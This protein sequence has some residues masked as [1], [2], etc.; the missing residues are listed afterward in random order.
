MSKIALVITFFF[1]ITS[2][3]KEETWSGPEIPSHFPEV[4][5]KN[6]QNRKFT[7]AGFLLGKRL[8]F[9]PILSV[10]STISCGSCHQQAGAFSHIDHDLSHG[11][12]DRLGKRNAPAIQNLLWN[13]TF[14]WDGGVQHIDLI[15][16]APIENDV[17]MDETIQNVVLKLNR[18]PYYK[19]AFKNIYQIDEIKTMDIMAAITEFQAMLVSSKSPY[20]Q[21]L[22]GSYTLS[23][24]E[25][26][27]KKLFED[28][29]ATC[30]SGVLQSDFMFRNNGIQLDNHL[31]KG[32][33]EITL[34]PED[35][36]KFK[37][38]SLRNIAITPPYMH[39]GSINTLEAVL[40]HYNSGIKQNPALDPKLK[41]GIPMHKDEQKAIIAFL[42]TLTD[43]NFVKD[44][45]F[46]F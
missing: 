21:F 46:G 19:E 9:D 42:K 44:A 30:H 34:N 2:C 4:A 18:N 35:E 43:Q 15:S 32:R 17:E 36:G 5:Q 45:R 37:T 8:F 39:N 31:D 38:P 24:I 41:N 3:Q 16:L 25:Q 1:L 23:S 13:N 27:G 6:M 11:V 10:D 40:E 7:K 14:F 26:E 12:M 22:K 33:Y 29:C 28:K 20:D